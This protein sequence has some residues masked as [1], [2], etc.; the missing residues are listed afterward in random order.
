MEDLQSAFLCVVYISFAFDLLVHSLWIKGF[1]LTYPFFL[2]KFTFFQRF[3]SRLEDANIYQMHFFVVFVMNVLGK[4]I[5]IWTI[6]YV[7]S[8]ISKLIRLQ[9]TSVTSKNKIVFLTAGCDGVIVCF[10]VTSSLENSFQLNLYG[11]G[12]SGFLVCLY[13]VCKSHSLMSDCSLSTK[14]H[15]LAQ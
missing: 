10:A 3:Y 2:L 4:F 1:D 15:L 11:V 14:R 7:G 8:V 12:E 13:R 5:A 9:F 6:L